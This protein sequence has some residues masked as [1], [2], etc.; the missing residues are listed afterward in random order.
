MEISRRSFL[1]GAAALAASGCATKAPLARYVAPGEIKAL[2]LHLGHNMWC[3]WF[4]AD[5]DA[6]AVAAAVAVS[7]G[8]TPLPD[9]ELRSKDDLWRKATDHAAAK[10]LNMIVIDLGEGLVYPSH[11]ELSIKGSWSPEKMRDEIARLNALGLEVIPKL[12]F[13]TTHNGWLKQYRR[14]LSTPTYYKVCEDIIADV[15]E[16]FDRPRFF[17]IGFDEETASHQNGSRRC[18]Y[19]SV[20]KGE[21]WW[22]DFLHIVRTVEK[23]GMRAWTWSDFGWDHPDFYTRCPKTVLMSNWYYDESYGGFELAE[24]KTSCHKRLKGFYDLDKAG[25]EQVPC[26]TNWAGW[27][28]KKLNIGA[29]DVI[30]KLVKLCRRDVSKQLLK[31]FLMAPWASCDTQEHLDFNIKGIDL[32]A[33]ALKA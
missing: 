22:Y 29:D 19:I 5:M 24:N 28:R 31:G 27:K 33:E 9:T 3:D 11:P 18:L 16:I 21:F 30:G 23:N 4:P 12:N 2:L 14:M 10:G 25:F 1:G 13:S 26:G 6:A 8:R 7:P 15:A 20:R 32:F 17:H